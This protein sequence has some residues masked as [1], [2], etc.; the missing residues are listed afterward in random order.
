MPSSWSCPWARI[1]WNTTANTSA[2]TVATAAIPSR[3]SV[4]RAGRD[5]RR[6]GANGTRAVVALRGRA[7]AGA[8]RT[9]VATQ[10]TAPVSRPRA[11]G[12]SSRAGSPRSR[13]QRDAARGASRAGRAA[14]AG[15]R[16]ARTGLGSSV[17]DHSVKRSFTMRSSSE[18]Y[19]STSRRPSGASRCTDSSSPAARLG[20]RGSP[21]CGWPGTCG[22]RGGH[23]DGARERGCRA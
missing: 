12:H 14:R 2:T 13:R 20:A 11:G 3:A 7:S 23:R 21:P 8:R 16:S 9:A 6:G 10:V 22:A 15:G 4:I 19:A 1:T 17:R 5:T 18:W